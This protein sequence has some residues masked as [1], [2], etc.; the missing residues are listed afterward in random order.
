MISVGRHNTFGHPSRETLERLAAAGI[1]V[2]RTD[3]CG[4]IH[5]VPDTPTI[6]PALCRGTR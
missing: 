4:A 2:F 3:A 6:E 1:I 5:I